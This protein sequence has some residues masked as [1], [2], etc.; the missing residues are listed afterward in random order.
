MNIILKSAGVAGLLLTLSGCE[1]PVMIAADANDAQMTGMFEITFPAM[2]LVQPEDSPELLYQGTLVGK[3][4]GSAKFFMTGSDG[5][6]CEGATNTKGVGQLVCDNGKVY[7]FPG[8]SER[9]K[10]SGL[11]VSE[12]AANGEAIVAAFGWGKLANEEALRSGI[13]EYDLG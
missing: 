11:V 1:I 13:A 6:N 4:S 12:G 3:A 2:F 7:P 9:P 8:Q 5:S 10:M